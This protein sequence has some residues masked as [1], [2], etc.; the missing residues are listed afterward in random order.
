MKRFNQN[1]WK[2]KIEP[3]V[4]KQIQQKEKVLKYEQ[5][6]IAYTVSHTY[7]PDFQLLNGVYIEVKGYFDMEDRRKHLCIKEQHPDIDIRFVFEKKDQKLRKNAKSSYADWCM[8]NGFKYSQMV[9]P[10][11]WFLKKGD[12]SA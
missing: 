1:K 7:T 8:K 6:K 5:S 12:K 3:I 2:S 10:D 9:I 11:E 4:G